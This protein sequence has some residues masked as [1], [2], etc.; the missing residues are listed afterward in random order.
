MFGAQLIDRKYSFINDINSYR[1]IIGKPQLDDV[2]NPLHT[3]RN[4]LHSSRQTKIH[5]RKV[6]T[7][8]SR[9]RKLRLRLSSE[10]NNDITDFYFPLDFNVKEYITKLEP[11]SRFNDITTLYNTHDELTDKKV[12]GTITHEEEVQLEKIRDK[13]ESYSNEENFIN[14]YENKIDNYQ[15][16]LKQI[17]ELKQILK[18]K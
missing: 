3:D 10:F 11:K 1:Q 12:L 9:K 16:L 4:L 5:N 18:K 17:K 7:A 15:E 6:R 13:L 14:F 2:Y 8:I